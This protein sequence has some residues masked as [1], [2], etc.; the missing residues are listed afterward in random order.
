MAAKK[1]TKKKSTARRKSA[2][3]KKSVYFFGG[4]KADD[5]ARLAVRSPR[6]HLLDLVREA[7]TGFNAT[8]PTPRVARLVWN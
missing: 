3:I 7:E 1:S 8:V 2:G 6:R 4:G 5:A